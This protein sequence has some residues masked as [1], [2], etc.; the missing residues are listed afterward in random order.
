[1]IQA[2]T[3]RL[4]RETVHEVEHSRSKAFPLGGRTM[5]TQHVIAVG[6]LAIVVLAGCGTSIP[7]GYEGLYRGTFSGTD[8]TIH[9]NGDRKSVGRERV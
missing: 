7:L 5:K 6:L 4:L 2:F 9:L 8:T 3:H 1:M